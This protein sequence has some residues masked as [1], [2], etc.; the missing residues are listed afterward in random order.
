MPK[1]TYLLSNFPLGLRILL[2]ILKVNG[3]Q[4]VSYDMH[5]EAYTKVKHFCPT[6]PIILCGNKKDLRGDPEYVKSLKD[7]GFNGPIT[8]DQVCNTVF[9]M[10]ILIRAL[11]W[12]KRLERLAITN[13]RL[14]QEK[15]SKNFS[16]RQFALF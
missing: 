8:Y 13:V 11:I 4:K 15:E 6:T 14:L 5:F 9:T 12:H 1:Q 10:L 16:K 3:F 2:T 7:K